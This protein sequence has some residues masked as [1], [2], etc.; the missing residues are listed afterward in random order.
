MAYPLLRNGLGSVVVV[1]LLVGCYTSPVNMSP[2][3]RIDTPA[4]PIQRGTR[5]PYTATAS[6]PDGGPPTLRWTKTAGVC[7]NGFEQPAQWPDTFMLQSF[8]IEAADTSS[9]WCVW[10]KASDSAGAATVDAVT[11]VAPD[12]APDAVLTLLSPPEAPSFPLHTTFV[13]SAGMSTDPDGEID[14]ANLQFNF[15]LKS[16]P[17]IAANPAIPGSVAQV[18]A[19]GPCPDTLNTDMRMNTD[20]RCLT[21]TVPGVFQ[22]EVQVSDPTGM[23]S[24]VDKF[25]TVSPGVPPVAVLDDIVTL[26]GLPPHL[27]STF[28]VSAASS[29]GNP[30]MFDW[31]S[32]TPAPGS[33]ASPSDC[34]G[35]PASMQVWCFTADVSGPYKVGLTVSNDSGSNMAMPK[36]IVVPP[37]Q[38]PCID[39]RMPSGAMTT[40]TDFSFAPTDDR[41]ADALNVQWL[42]SDANGTTFSPRL[43][44]NVLSFSLNPAEFTFGDFVKVR[45]EIRDRDIQRGDDAFLACG[46]VADTCSAASSIHPDTCF[47]RFTWTVHILP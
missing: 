32:F 37:D 10:V 41:D 21:A 12:R 31:S 11:F 40:L 46:N 19:F 5:V 25:L 39:G 3:V 47:Q 33:A 24:V 28:K 7:P 15:K 29:T 14:H 35:A 9:I 22:V 16:Q 13:L 23:T 8:G 30:T 1:V 18:D 42:V 2:I 45:V 34:A 26:D 17:S 4:T 44:G 6:D 38:P 27:G 20:V 36:T 43:K